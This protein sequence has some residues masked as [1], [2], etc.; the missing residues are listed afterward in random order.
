L[1]EAAD[2]LKRS[3]FR[4]G[5]VTFLTRPDAEK[6]V[7]HQS[8]AEGETAH[9][10]DAV[11]L[12]ITTRPPQV[13]VP[14]VI[15]LTREAA[16]QR[17]ENAGLGVGGYAFVVRTDRR[18]GI[19]SQTPAAGSQADSGS[20]VDL[21]ENRPPEVRRVQVPD[22]RGRTIA[23]SERMLRSVGLV[24]GE[25]L[26]PALNAVDR[27]KEQRPQPGETVVMNSA[28][29]IGLDVIAGPGPEKM[30]RIPAVVNLTVDSARK[31]LTDSGFTT[32][33]I[34]GG[35]DRFASASIVESQTPPAG[36]FALPATLLT[37]VAHAPPRLPPMPNLVG[38]RRDVA[39]VV[40]ELDSLR[41]IVVSEIRSFRLHDEVVRQYP[42]AQ[43]PR[44]ADNTVDVFVEIPIVPA[45]IALAVLGLG[46]VGGVGGESVRRWRKR[47]R[48]KQPT[49]AVTLKPL[50]SEPAPPELHAEALGSLIK[51]SFTLHFGV[52]SSPSTLEVEGDSL[53]KPEK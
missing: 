27:V 6:K 31:T 40:A 4:A 37:L 23:A 15:T 45:P 42:E 8:P 32:I 30:I 24:L 52:E 7:V 5:H 36:T 16:R 29:I 2:S 41:M 46:V 47:N 43:R 19:V 10:N 53:V 1:A 12:T 34:G 3:G 11:D 18:S 13:A 51:S 50:A 35:G 28:V 38:Q 33:S 14:S 49:S 9:R 39:D 25:V 48:V 21:E 44:R 22:L 26:R 17:L 20:L